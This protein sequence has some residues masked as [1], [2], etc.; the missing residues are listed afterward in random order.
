MIIKQS[1][2][3][4]FEQPDA[5]LF[6]GTIIDVIDLGLVKTRTIKRADRFRFVQRR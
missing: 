3:K 2:K 1:E 6:L 4:L 5:G